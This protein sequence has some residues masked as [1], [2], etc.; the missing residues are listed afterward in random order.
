MRLRQVEIIAFPIGYQNVFSLLLKCLG[1]YFV[2]GFVGLMA[3]LVSL[4]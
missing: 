4:L 2:V 1:D 3:L